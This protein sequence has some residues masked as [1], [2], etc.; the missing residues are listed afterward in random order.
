L[1]TKLQI[2]SH[3]KKK[4]RFCDKFRAVLTLYNTTQ[5]FSVNIFTKRRAI[6][7]QVKQ[8]CDPSGG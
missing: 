1:A 6:F 4:K 3:I 8:A 2:L 7:T 5:S